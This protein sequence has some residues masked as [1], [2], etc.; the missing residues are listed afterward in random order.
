MSIKE[1]RSSVIVLRISFI[2][3]CAVV[4]EADTECDVSEENIA[5]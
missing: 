1:M 3:C 2:V 5:A 4:S